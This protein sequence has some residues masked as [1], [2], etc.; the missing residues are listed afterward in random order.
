MLNEIDLYVFFLE[1]VCIN[2]FA[3]FFS[4]AI[5]LK[6]KKFLIKIHSFIHLVIFFVSNS[7]SCIKVK[8]TYFLNLFLPFFQ[9]KF[10]A[11]AVYD[12]IYTNLV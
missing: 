7:L 9:T 3:V 10:H 6:K 4:L 1:P 5:V 2:I 12:S 11:K 8:G